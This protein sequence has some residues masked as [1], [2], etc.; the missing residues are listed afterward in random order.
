[1]SLPIGNLT[2]LFGNLETNPL[3]EIITKEVVGINV[4]RVAVTRSWDERLDVAT[5]EAGNTIG[6]FGPTL[7]IDRALKKFLYKPGM[8]ENALKWA[9][10][11]HSAGVLF[12]LGGIM[13][14]MPFIRNYITTKRT[15]KVDFADVISK[16]TGG[17]SPK[18]AEAVVEQQKKTAREIVNIMGMFTA[19]GLAGVLG[20]KAAATKNLNMGKL[21]TGIFNKFAF[22]QEGFMSMKKWPTFLFWGATSYAGALM[23]ARDKFEF[24]E[25]IL[26]FFT[27]NFG[28]FVPDMVFEKVFDPK[29]KNTMGDALYNTVAK[30]G[31]GKVK[32]KH[33][34]NLITDEGVK[35]AATGL[36]LKRNV[37]GLMSSIMLLGVLPQLTN[38]YLTKKRMTS[39][40]TEG[41]VNPL[42]NQTPLLQQ[43]QLQNQHF[44]QFM[45]GVSR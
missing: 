40:G 37:M 8:S 5:F 34:Q 27:F 6:S 43:K 7:L 14:A 23:G 45:Q 15:G 12:P 11:A 22:T 9:R 36:W 26:K 17:Q 44:K 30:A 19:L 32:Y 28:F 13:W 35:K 16:N 39:T 24:K 20:G 38:I 42:Q 33:I 41:G 4:P 3:K 2:K 25:Q 29:F 21:M 18:N 1:M 10:M 31:K